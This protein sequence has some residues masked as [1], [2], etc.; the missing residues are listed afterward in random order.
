MIPSVLSGLNL[1]DENQKKWFI[2]KKVKTLIF[3][4][5]IMQ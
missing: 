2:K 4:R 1:D 5:Q 3:I